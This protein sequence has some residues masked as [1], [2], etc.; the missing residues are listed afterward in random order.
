MEGPDFAADC[1]RSTA[2]VLPSLDPDGKFARV[3][4]GVTWRYTTATGYKATVTGIIGSG[5]ASGGLDYS[6]ND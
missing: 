1:R 6:F 3:V 4:D 2:I 5:D